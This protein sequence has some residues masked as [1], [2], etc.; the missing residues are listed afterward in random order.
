VSPGLTEGKVGDIARA[1]VR[2]RGGTR[3]FPQ[4][5][6]EAV[7]KSAGAYLLLFGA[8]ALRAY[9]LHSFGKPFFR[10]WLAVIEESLAR[11]RK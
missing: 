8:P 10:G 2:I 5:A 9:L 4:K 3:A 7:A 11:R 1:S 6:Y